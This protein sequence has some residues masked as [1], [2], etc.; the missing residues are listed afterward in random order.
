MTLPEHPWLVAE[1]DHV[2]GYAYAAS[3]GSRAA[4][5]WSTDVSVY[6]DQAARGQGVG[7]AL[8]RAL[9]KVLDLQG[10]R[11]AFA[12]ITLPNGASVALHESLGFVPVG[13]YR[14]VG[15]KLGAWHDVGHW[16]RRIAQW[17][18]EGPGRLRSVEGSSR[19]VDRNSCRRTA[20][21]FH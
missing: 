21:V 15:W 10:F 20:R 1:R 18:A 14:Q 4:Y 8:Y 9:F 19:Q 13:I 6:V 2:V 16:Q 11:E 3:H 5:R 17:T 7:R 12:G